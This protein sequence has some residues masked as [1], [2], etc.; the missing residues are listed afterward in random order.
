MDFLRSTMAFF[1]VASAILALGG[2][3][4]VVVALVPA[5]AGQ[6][7]APDAMR[8][9]GKR[10]APVV[11]TAVVLFLVTGVYL[12]FAR[13]LA[14]GARPFVSMTQWLLLATKV[15]FSLVI[16]VHALLVTLPVKA[17]EAAPAKKLALMRANLFI[18]LVVVAIGVFLVRW[19]R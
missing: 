13:Y 3:F 16:L 8:A 12:L 17:L 4:Y 1:H 5:L 14:A 18:G 6:P 11:W 2:T 15:V 9:A 7:N 10:F 19:P